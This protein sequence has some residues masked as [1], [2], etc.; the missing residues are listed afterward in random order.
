[1]RPA[2]TTHH[3]LV[4]LPKEIDICQ[5]GSIFGE[6][7]WVRD[8]V[9]R[10]D[11]E[12]LMIYGYLDDRYS[13]LIELTKQGEYVKLDCNCWDDLCAGVLVMLRS[14]SRILVETRPSL[15]KRWEKEERNG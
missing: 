12:R 13:P 11:E 4:N 5:L 2:C 7:D 9:L 3:H 8:V 1:M 10:K 14:A 15:E 6:A